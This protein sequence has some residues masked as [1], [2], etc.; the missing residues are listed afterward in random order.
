MKKGL[1]GK[2]A[3]YRIRGKSYNPE[4]NL[5]E[6]KHEADCFCCRKN[7]LKSGVESSKT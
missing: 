3:G 7:L 5:I 6:E 2:F 4:G 1:M